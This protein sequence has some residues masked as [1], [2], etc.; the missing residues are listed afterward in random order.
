MYE[1]QSQ[2]IV[3]IYLIDK[4]VWYD[5]DFC[6]NPNSVSG[7]SYKF[8]DPNP[9]LLGFHGLFVLDQQ[10]LIIT[11]IIDLDTME[12]EISKSDK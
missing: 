1:H 12:V 2:R 8:N 10:G 3:S 11:T 9:K 5:V 4:Q 6:S 7:L